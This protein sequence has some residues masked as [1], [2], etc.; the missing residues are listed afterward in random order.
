MIIFISYYQ[1]VTDL[2]FR[3]YN[4]DQFVLGGAASAGRGE[5]GE[6]LIQGGKYH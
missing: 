3:K 4:I 1:V 2:L 6:T 5:F